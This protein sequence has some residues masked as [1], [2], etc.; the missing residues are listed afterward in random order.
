MMGTEGSH[1][2]EGRV[3]H[4]DTLF[5]AGF[6]MMSL[7]HFF[8][9]KLGGSLHGTGKG[10]LTPFGLEVVQR[11][12][13][14]EIILDVAHSSPAVLRDVL[15][16]S[17]RPL[18]VSHTGIYGTCASARNF[19]DQLMREIAAA[20]GLIAIGYWKAAVCDITPEGVATA[21]SFAVELLGEDHVALG[22]DFDGGTKTAFDTAE[23]AVITQALLAAGLSETAIRKVMGENS[24]QFL[25]RWLPQ[26]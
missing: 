26:A 3:E 16:V 22:S 2:L 12:H 15:A 19:P 20:G 24:I 25:L 23:L 5:E 7:Q 1:A 18:V 13:E 4:V 8:D 11:I 14:R 21:I 9:N 6:R 10:G 17:E